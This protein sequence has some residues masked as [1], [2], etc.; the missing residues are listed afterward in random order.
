M[1]RVRRKR[2]VAKTKTRSLAS[3]YRIIEVGSDK[4]YTTIEAAAAA[5]VTIAPDDNDPVL[6]HL[7]AGSYTLTDAQVALPDN[8]GIIAR[9][10]TPAN[11]TI[12]GKDGN[13]QGDGILQIGSGHLFE[14]FTI[15]AGA[16]TSG[17]CFQTVRDSDNETLFQRMIFADQGDDVI[18]TNHGGSYRLE[19]SDVTVKW[20]GIFVKQLSGASAVI[21]KINNSYLQH[22]ADT[23][24]WNALV[25]C[26]I[27]DADALIEINSSLLSA[28]ASTTPL[29]A[30]AINSGGL[31]Q[32]AKGYSLIMR[33]STIRT[34]VPAGYAG[35]ACFA[36]NKDTGK[37]DALNC[38]FELTDS[39][40]SGTDYCI[41]TDNCTDYENGFVNC[42][43][44]GAGMTIAQCQN[45]G[46][47]NAITGLPI[48]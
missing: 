16:S 43:V 29:H 1:I 27:D 44:S 7:D 15:G 8:S 9:D 48:S 6:I 38:S 34:D 40:R 23:A 11:T 22:G 37:M 19:R 2:R 12:T 30:T 21:F 35:N 39:P 45:I 17:A 26:D 42:T 4:A 33:G 31:S 20:D 10:T 24:N 46:V 25:R 28:Q 5:L 3:S 14:G 36:I 13:P 18:I 32:V 41:D 47:S